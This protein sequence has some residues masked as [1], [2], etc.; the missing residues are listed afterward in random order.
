VGQRGSGKNDHRELVVKKVPENFQ[1]SSIVPGQSQLSHLE[2][3]RIAWKEAWKSK[4]FR[5]HSELTL[6]IIISFSVIF[7]R[8]FDF[9]EARSGTMLNDYLLNIIPA[10]NVSWVVFFFLYSGILTGIYYHLIHPRTIL[11]ICQTYVIVTLLRI[12][13]IS[14]WPLEP[15]HG[16]LPL[17]EPFVQLFTSEGKIISKDLF[18]SGHMSTILSLYFASHRKY[19][20][21]FLLLCSIMIGAMVLLQHVHYTID[22]LFAVPATYAVFYFCKKYLGGNT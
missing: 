17:R 8:F 6:M 3:T 2:Q 4:S 13:T 21:T 10:Y 12:G 1:K 20:R 18:F 11:I 9:I 7:N 5:I 15:P 19:V 14:L 22:V 16:Y